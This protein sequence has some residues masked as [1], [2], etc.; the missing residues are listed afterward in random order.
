MNK[1]KIS[2]LQLFY[3]MAGYVLGTAMVLGLGANVKQDAWL[4]IIFGMLCSLILMAVYT[5]LSAYY[6]GETLVQ[7]LPKI[8]GKYLSYPVILL[9][10]MHFTYSAA[11]AGRELGDLIVTTILA[12]TPI[13]VVIGSFMMLMIYCLRGGVET[14]GRMAEIVFPIYIFSLMLIWI[15]LLTVEQFDVKN[16]LL[17]F[18]QPSVAK[19]FLLQLAGHQNQHYDLLY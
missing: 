9:Y 3:I 8:I 2:S 13:F 19:E 12:E 7:M 6:P 4:F 18:L 15:L 10:I 16:L 11:R 17:L 5:Q 1:E 14:F